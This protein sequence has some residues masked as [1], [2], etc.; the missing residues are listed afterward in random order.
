MAV[1]KPVG[2][3]P[4]GLKSEELPAG[5]RLIRIHRKLHQPVWFGP[6]AGTP[7][8][9]RFDAPNG[10]YRMLYAAAELE[11]AFVETVLHRPMGRIIAPRYLEER[12]WSELVPARPLKIAKLYDEGLLWHG[13]DA[14]IS[15]NDDYDT[16]RSMA[17]DLFQH[18][19]DLDGIGYRARHD[20]GMICY[21]LFDRVQPGEL[22]VPQT[23]AFQDHW[24]RTKNLLHLYGAVLDTSGPVPAP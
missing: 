24:Q 8:A 22:D 5:G 16:S 23:F 13:V 4:Q 6:P 14:S 21:A 11:G 19:P 12:A 15:A 20:N 3:F 1:P 7:P 9:N 2:P 17:L 18:F 10:E